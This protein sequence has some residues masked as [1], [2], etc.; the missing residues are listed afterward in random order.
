MDSQSLTLLV[1]IIDSGNLSQAA[2]KL[3][4]TRANVSYHLTQLEKAGVQLVKRTTRRVEPTEIGMRLYEHGRNIHNEM[5]AAREAIT[6]LGQSLQGRVGISVPSG[7]GQIV[8][9]EWL[10]EF[11]RLYPG[12]VL[13]VLFENRADNLRDDVD[14]IVRVIQ[15]PPLSLVARSLGTVRYLACAS[16]EYAQTHGLPR[17]LHALRAS[18]LI[19]AGVTGRQLRLAAYLGTERHEVMLEPTM[20]SEHFPFCATASWPAWG[21]PG[22]RLCGAGQAGH[23]RGAEHAGRVPAQHFRHPYVSALPAQPASDQGRAHLHRFSAGQGPARS[24]PAGRDAP[25]LSRNAKRQRAGWRF[26]SEEHEAFSGQPAA[27]ILLAPAAGALLKMLAEPARER[28]VLGKA[29]LGCRFAHRQLRILQRTQRGLAAHG[30]QRFLK[31]GVLGF[32]VPLQRAGRVAKRA[33]HMGNAVAPVGQQR[34]QGAAHLLLQRS[35]HG[36]RCMALHQAAGVA[37]HEAVVIG[38]DGLQILVAHHDAIE[39]RA[40]HDLAAQHAAMAHGA[41][42]CELCEKWMLA[43]LQCLP[44]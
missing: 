2:R 38:I 24:N 22:A 15:E 39:V 25:A 36:P 4:M 26:H 21:G 18:P 34:L 35:G 42:R 29:G 20:I 5:L 16:R 12:I 31:A 6:A 41:A 27:Q 37:L 3:K 13:D 28:A 33:G 10:I 30:V 44:S 1:E 19:T 7:Y 17:T 9:S 43:G 8:M 14:I 32:E 40:E 11:K 23:G